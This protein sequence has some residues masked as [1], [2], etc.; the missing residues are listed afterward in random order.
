MVSVCVCVCLSV[1]GTR[2]RCLTAAEK[3][4]VREQKEAL[5]KADFLRVYLGTCTCW[6]SRSYRR[7]T[8]LMS[9]LTSRSWVRIDLL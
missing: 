8:R 7:L 9:C 6:P 2:S 5:R 1:A 3:G 4:R